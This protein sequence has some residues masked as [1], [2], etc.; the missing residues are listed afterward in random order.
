MTLPLHP[1]G[2]RGI[3]IP[4][5]VVAWI[6]VG[7]GW[8]VLTRGAHPTRG[9]AFAVTGA[10]LV[11]YAAVSYSELFALRR[12]TRGLS[13]WIALAACMLIATAGALGVI[14]WAYTGAGYT[15]GPWAL[16]YGIDLVG[17]IAHV[18]GAACVAL[19]WRRVFPQGR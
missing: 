4:L 15:P 2:R 3:S 10:L 19:V 12:W 17:M 18:G 5:G 1:L 11:A 7:V 9:L 6:C 16:H 8:Y 14:R 13:Y